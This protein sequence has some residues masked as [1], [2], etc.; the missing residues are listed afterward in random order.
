[1][2]SSPDLQQ[3]VGVELPGKKPDGCRANWDS[4]TS[5]MRAAGVRSMSLLRQLLSVTGRWELRLDAVLSGLG[6]SSTAP[7][8]QLRGTVPAHGRLSNSQG[9]ARLATRTRWRSASPCILSG[10]GT[11]PKSN[12]RRV[13]PGSAIFIERGPSHSSGSVAEG[14]NSGVVLLSPP[15]ASWGG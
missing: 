12:S 13:R 15:T 9:T 1:M 10:P 5:R 4:M 8:R 6:R 2:H 3:L 11:G 7:R 14:G